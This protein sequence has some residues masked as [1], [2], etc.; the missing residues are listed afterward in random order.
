METTGTTLQEGQVN[1]KNNINERMNKLAAE[2]SISEDK[3]K[4]MFG[5]EEKKFSNIH[6][7]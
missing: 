1:L 5:L 2:L 6:L 4:Q 3:L 7:S